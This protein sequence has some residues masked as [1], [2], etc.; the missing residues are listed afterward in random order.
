M[1]LEH[2]SEGSGE[3]RHVIVSK[4][5]AES[6]QDSS[7]FGMIN[8]GDANRKTL[9]RAATMEFA[10]RNDANLRPQYSLGQLGDTLP[11]FGNARDRERDLQRSKSHAEL[12]RGFT[13]SP[14]PSTTIS[15]AS[16]T[17]AMQ[18]N[19]ARYQQL[20]GAGGLTNVPSIT[21]TGTNSGLGLRDDFLSK[22]FSS[23][24][25]STPTINGSP[26]RARDPFSGFAN[27]S[28]PFMQTAPIGSNRTTNSNDRNP[29]RH[30]QGPPADG[31][32]GFERRNGQGRGSDEMRRDM[33]GTMRADS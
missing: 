13:P 10:E 2:I 18:N 17:S 20:D 28:Q 31:G 8:G 11:T 4:I 16:F 30:P 14:A 12:Q 27:D 6:P 5:R 29:S 7:Y 23:M 33:K 19:A 24:T 32:Q 9:A 3:G 21:H 26:R 25:I 22:G 15:N 1:G